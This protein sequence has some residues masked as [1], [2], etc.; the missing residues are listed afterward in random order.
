M[1]F[2]LH[3]HLILRRKVPTPTH[4]NRFLSVEVKEVCYFEV[5]EQKL[6]GILKG[7]S[8]EYS[9]E[10]Q[11]VQKV[12]LDIYNFSRYLGYFNMQPGREL[13]P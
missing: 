9:P 10:Y 2:K 13:L 1:E 5:H 12:G 4:D 6:V 8:I 7:L 3:I 11:T